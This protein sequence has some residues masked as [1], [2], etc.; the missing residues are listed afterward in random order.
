MK[1]LPFSIGM[2]VGAKGVPLKD[3]LPSF[4]ALAA[5]KDVFVADYHEQVSGSF[6]WL[7]VFCAGC[8][9]G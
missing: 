9:C 7:P 4:Y 2:T 6:V 5:N 3:L 1:D 8:L